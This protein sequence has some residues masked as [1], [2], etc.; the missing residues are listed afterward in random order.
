MTDFSSVMLF[1]HEPKVYQRYVEINEL[2][3]VKTHENFDIFLLVI[4]HYSF[5]SFPLSRQKQMS[6]ERK[7]SENFMCPVMLFLHEPKG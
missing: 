4:R 1:F 2:K 7:E 6:I 3:F 5:D